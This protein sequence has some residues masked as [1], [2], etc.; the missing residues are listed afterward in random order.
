MK[1]KETILLIQPDR[2]LRKAIKKILEKSGYEV[3]TAGEGHEALDVLSNNTIDLVISALRMPGINGMELM[4]EISRT[5]MS[6]PV[7]FLTAYGDVESYMDLMNM[8]AFDYINL[9]VNDH[10]ILRVTRY[11]LEDQRDPSHS[12]RDSIAKAAAC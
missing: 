3:V 7:I 5:R 9:P 10:E 12:R 4:G 11:A 8:G 2:E 1:S 6:V